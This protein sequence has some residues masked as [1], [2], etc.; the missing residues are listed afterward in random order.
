MSLVIRHL[1]LGHLW[2]ACQT[3][4]FC[5]QIYG[6]TLANVVFSHQA[7]A[8]LNTHAHFSASSTAFLDS[9]ALM[10]SDYHVFMTAV[11]AQSNAT[12][13]PWTRIHQTRQDMYL[14]LLMKYALCGHNE[15]FDEN[16]GVCICQPGKTCMSQ[17][18]SVTR[19]DLASQILLGMII[20][21][22]TIGLLVGA[23]RLQPV[24]H[25]NLRLVAQKNV[26]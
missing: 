25:P 8:M 10:D 2:A 3:N 9:L 7:T 23:C 6:G 18:Y 17:A 16:I 15:L 24:P 22:I 21:L 26:G 11:M 5:I 14:Q 13:Y 19:R 1:F 4:P 12:A 20:A